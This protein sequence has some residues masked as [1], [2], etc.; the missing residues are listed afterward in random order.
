MT[1]LIVATEDRAAGSRLAGLLEHCGFVEQVEPAALLQ[2]VHCRRP[3][4]ILLDSRCRS[5]D[6]LGV[7]RAVL[8]ADP[9]L[10]VVWMSG[11]FDRSAQEAVDAGAYDVIL[12]PLDPQRILLAVRRGLERD[13]LLRG[14]CDAYH[15]DRAG[16]AAP[17]PAKA[18]STVYQQLAGCIARWF[19]DL[20]RLGEEVLR[21][22]REQ[23]RFGALMLF[24]SS[25]GRFVPLASLG[26]DESVGTRLGFGPDHPLAAWLLRHRRLL[27]LSGEIRLPQDIHDAL[28][29]MRA[30]MV[31]PLAAQKGG[32]LGFLAVGAKV[33]G[34]E[35]TQ[36][37]ID[38][39]S[40]LCDYLAIVFENARLYNEIAFEREFQ[41]AVFANIPSGVAGVDRQGNVLLLNPVAER[42]LDVAAREARGRPVETLGSQI[43]D[44]LRRTLAAEPFVREEFVYAPTGAVLGI[45]TARIAG[46]GGPAG[47]VAVFQDLTRLKELER[48][49]RETQRIE[50]WSVLASYLAHALKNPLVAIKSFAHLL[51]SRFNDEEFRVSFS[52]IVQQEVERI[53]EIVGKIVALAE[54]NL[55]SQGVVEMDRLVENL[56][57]K[58]KGR[59]AERD[60][61]LEV[62]VCHCPPVAGDAVR[63]L[64]AVE[65]LLEFS[66]ED[67]GRAGSIEIRLSVDADLVRLTVAE[68]GS[69]FVVDAGLFSPYSAEMPVSLS[70]GLIL[71]RKIVEAHGGK[72]SAEQERDGKRFVCEMP[73]GQEMMRRLAEER[74]RGEGAPKQTGG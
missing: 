69:R 52:R 14:R 29:L 48:R 32:L 34:A 53:D 16:S 4:L 58:W 39:L 37:D 12:L 22:L 74:K 30:E 33:T 60:I 9:T 61:V 13:R 46:S 47:A 27:R 43:A 20:G 64:E 10:T 71:A 51:P 45:S 1:C 5:G 25:E 66:K 6:C 55:R 36:T 28:S 41:N 73:A 62:S 19:P 3:S 65:Y 54:T 38:D 7:L 67:V 24:C 26:V 40:M 15:P 2:A 8:S 50:A 72:I 68:S 42:L 70:I 63:M 31:F 44:Y 49:E 57:Q 11:A 23:V 56:A 21:V 17:A 18:D 59:L 35:T